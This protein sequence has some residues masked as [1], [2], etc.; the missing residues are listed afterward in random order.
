M[1]MFHVVV[2]PGVA[3]VVVPGVVVVACVPGVVVFGVVVVVQ[4][5]PGYRHWNQGQCRENRQP[6]SEAKSYR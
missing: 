1:M 3:V 6:I 5:S 2:V 4:V